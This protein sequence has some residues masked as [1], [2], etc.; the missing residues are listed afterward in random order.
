M[1]LI[2]FIIL[3]FGCRGLELGDGPRGG[4]GHLPL[5]PAP[6]LL[7]TYVKSHVSG[8]G[9]AG[10][11]QAGCRE[12]NMLP[13]LFAGKKA[14]GFAG[15][16]DYYACPTS[17]SMGRDTSWEKRRALCTP[18]AAMGASCLLL[19]VVSGEAAACSCL[20]RAFTCAWVL[21]EAPSLRRQAVRA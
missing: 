10:S 12:R 11:T 13:H 20:P 15:V 8:G 2:L 1:C 18:A 4:F 14:L 6:T 17:T 5:S 19:L 21:R 3:L 9:E 7:H 16:F